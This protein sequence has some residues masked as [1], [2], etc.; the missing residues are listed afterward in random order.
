MKLVNKL[1]LGAFVLFAPILVKAAPQPV[2][3]ANIPL[4][5]ANLTETTVTISST[6]GTAAVLSTAT[7]TRLAFDIQVTTC[8][9]VLQ[10]IRIWYAFD[11]AGVST[12]TI[13]GTNM[14]NV[15]NPFLGSTEQN[16]EFRF[17][18][19]PVNIV[20]Q[21]AVYMRSEA[22][23]VGACYAIVREWTTSSQNF[24]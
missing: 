6:S 15:M 20:H 19:Q 7:A 23:S 9:G 16:P 18:H 14:S 11:T 8:T 4:G 3:T 13:T 12:G 1:L 24:Q 10:P 2:Y 5:P 22:S 17:V 21:G